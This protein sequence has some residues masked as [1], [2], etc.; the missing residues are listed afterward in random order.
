LEEAL[1]IY[2]G[3]G[4]LGGQARALQRVGQVHQQRGELAEAEQILTDVLGMV[5]GS[6]DVIGEGHLLHDL[7][8]VNVLMGRPTQAEGFFTRAL[9]VR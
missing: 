7:G 4:Y 3:S 2:R 6:G 8:R 9:S 5:S 1:E